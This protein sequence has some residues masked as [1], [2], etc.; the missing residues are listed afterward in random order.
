M[1]DRAI[2]TTLSI[3]DPTNQHESFQRVLFSLTRFSRNFIR[4]KII[5]FLEYQSIIYLFIFI[6]IS[7]FIEFHSI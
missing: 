5:V 3:V 4:L 2:L 6:I 7:L 1:F